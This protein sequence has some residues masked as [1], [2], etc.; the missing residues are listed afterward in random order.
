[1]FDTQQPIPA[2]TKASIKAWN[3][4]AH[5]MSASV[6]GSRTT[7]LSL[8]VRPVLAPDS[9]ASAPLDTRWLPGSY[10][11]ACTFTTS[12]TFPHAVTRTAAEVVVLVARTVCSSMAGRAAQR[13]HLSCAHGQ[14]MSCT[15]SLDMSNPVG[16]DQQECLST[17]SYSSAGV[18]L[19]YTTVGLR[20]ASDM[21]DM[22]VTR[23]PSTVLR[24]SCWDRR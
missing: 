20:P 18:R 12:D 22:K 11:S 10:S 4:G 9:V 8:G 2:E 15:A 24:G 7:R 13:C 3:I 14:G 21:A 17:F 19:W 16:R 5:Q 6:S 23:A 1:M